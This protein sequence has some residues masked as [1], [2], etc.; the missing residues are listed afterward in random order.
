MGMAV[1]TGTVVGTGVEAEE[2]FGV[3][4]SVGTGVVFCHAGSSS[5]EAVLAAGTG[6][7]TGVGDAVTGMGVAVKTTACFVG[8][9]DTE[10]MYVGFC[11]GAGVGV[12]PGAGASVEVRSDICVEDT[13]G[14]GEEA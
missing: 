12:S 4:T 9:E 6:V 1:R 13:V 14:F 3:E 5:W 10:A 8:V 7:K 11:T 2:G